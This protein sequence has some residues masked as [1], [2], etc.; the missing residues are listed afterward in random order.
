MADPFLLSLFQLDAHDS[1]LVFLLARGAQLRVNFIQSPEEEDK[2][3]AH[4]TSSF[5]PP[6]SERVERSDLAMRYFS[7]ISAKKKEK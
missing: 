1:S 4:T 5:E 3:V 6:V 7:P 2:I